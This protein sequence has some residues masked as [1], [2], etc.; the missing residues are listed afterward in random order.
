[1]KPIPK[2]L[3][4]HT[5]ALQQP[6]SKNAWGDSSSDKQEL[7]FIRIDPC[8]KLISDKTQRQV[9]ASVVLFFDCRNSR[10]KGTVFAE[11]QTVLWNDREYT[12]RSI[13]PLYDGRKLHHW[14]V[15]LE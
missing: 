1:M 5:A 4:I 8:S 9:Q 12:V 11:E 14:E 3:L 7:T 15:T 2:H 13:E 6:G 10:P